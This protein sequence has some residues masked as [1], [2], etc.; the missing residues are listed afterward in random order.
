[1]NS[2]MNLLIMSQWKYLTTNTWTLLDQRYESSRLCRL[3]DERLEAVVGDKE[4]SECQRIHDEIE[5]YVKRTMT[6]MIKW[7]D[8]DMTSS[9]VIFM[10]ERH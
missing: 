2:L 6:V 4:Q 9:Y 8:Y 1:M 7:R 5:D 10:L 3:G